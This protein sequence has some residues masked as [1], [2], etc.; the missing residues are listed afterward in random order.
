MFEFKTKRMKFEFP[1]KTFYRTVSHEML[2]DLKSLTDE[3]QKIENQDEV[4]PYCEKMINKILGEG[5]VEQIFYGRE[6]TIDDL[7]DVIVYIIEEMSKQVKSKQVK[8]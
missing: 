4:R 3:A 6:I 7:A 2:A 5:A 1:N 8:M